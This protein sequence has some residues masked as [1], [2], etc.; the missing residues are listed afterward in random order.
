LLAFQLTLSSLEFSGYTYRQSVCPYCSK[1]LAPTSKFRRLQTSSFAHCLLSTSSQTSLA[2][3]LGMTLDH[4]CR[5]LAPLPI[6]LRVFRGSFA[7]SSKDCLV[8]P[9]ILK[10]S[11]KRRRRQTCHAYDQA[12]FPPSLA[13][14]VTMRQMRQYA[15]RQVTMDS[16]AYAS[17]R[18]ALRSLH[19]EHRTGSYGVLASPHLSQP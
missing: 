3:L 19:Q 2:Q 6:H 16:V 4:S 1:I 7:R 9:R 13:S 12:P 17:L 14:G 8:S 11:V 5:G 10:S 15:R 18:Y